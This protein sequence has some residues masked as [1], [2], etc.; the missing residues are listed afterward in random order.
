M[1]EN[2]AT[3][4]HEGGCLCGAVR[5]RIAGSLD[6]AAHC[7]CSMCRR[8]SGAPFVTWVVVPI[9]GFEVVAGEPVVYRSSADSERRF[10]PNCGAQLT[11]WT[12]RA[13]DTMDVTVGTLDDPERC[14]ANRHIWTSSQLRSL[15][16]DDRLPAFPEETPADIEKT[17]PPDE[18]A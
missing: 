16:V 7:H 6:N 13:A 15:H 8:A 4:V 11:F 17:R 1:S 10:C 18:P 12:S 9:D 3:E 5:Y 2:G 14:R